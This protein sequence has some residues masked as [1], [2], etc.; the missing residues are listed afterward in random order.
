[1]TLLIVFAFV[2]GLATVVSPCVLPVLP[3]VLSTSVGGGRLRP[4][5]VVL[6]LAV[7]FTAATLAAA[8]AVQALALPA[9]WLRTVA[10]VALG[11]FG[12][13]ML[14]P[15]WERAIER[16]LSPLAR[17]AGGVGGRGTLR[18][19]S[20]GL[21]NGFGGGLLLGAGLGLVWAP[22]VGPIMA[23]VIALAVQAGVSVE[24]AAITLAYALGAGVP[25][26]AIGYGARSVADGARSLRPRAQAMRRVFGGLTVLACLALLFGLESRLANLVPAEWSD[27][28]TV[29][30]RQEA[31]QKE[32]T[33]LETGNQAASLPPAPEAIR[34]AQS[35]ATPAPTSAPEVAAPTPTTVTPPAPKE[36][37][38]ALKDLGPAPE[39]TGLAGWIN[40]EPLTLSDLRGK[41]VIVDFWTFGC[42]NCRNTT[43]HVRALYDK[44]KSEGLE[45]LGI[46]TP[47]FAYERVPENVRQATRDQGV[48]WPVALD[49]DF[50]TWRAYNNRYWPAF[51]FIDASGHVRHTHFGEGN[52][53]YNEKVVQQLLAEART[54]SR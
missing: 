15:A 33:T 3:V 24:G 10:I 32:I 22:C 38:L 20:G 25:M 23:S 13:S 7:S 48:T 12:L 40:S 51:Y 9:A 53:E 21:R 11:V 1:M 50:K 45:I 43:P 46:H 34:P 37:A 36:P 8:G 47:E 27:A 19:R 52:Y 30:E 28:L 4:L 49:P 16:L 17:F 6:G 26:L 2:A 41:V 5:G 44:Y 39:L 18:V 54:A 14:L 31:V 35:A 29:F 42:Y